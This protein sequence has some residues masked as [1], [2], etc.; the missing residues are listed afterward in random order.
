MFKLLTL[1]IKNRKQKVVK[2]LNKYCQLHFTSVSWQIICSN[3]RKEREL[4]TDNRREA[5]GTRRE[6]TSQGNRTREEARVHPSSR[7][8]GLSSSFGLSINHIFDS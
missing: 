2:K 8:L 4:M 7:A 1:T 3:R 5:G 6:E